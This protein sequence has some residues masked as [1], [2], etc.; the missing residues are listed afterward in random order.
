[1]IKDQNY[2]IILICS[3]D[4]NRKGSYR[5]ISQHQNLLQRCNKFF[6]SLTSLYS[7]SL[8]FYDSYVPFIFFPFIFFPVV[9]FTIRTFHKRLHSTLDRYFLEAIQLSMCKCRRLLTAMLLQIQNFPFHPIH[10][11]LKMQ[12]LNHSD[13]GLK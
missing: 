8:F 3:V 9:F 7:A 5:K 10:L 2:V 1:M 11:N 6:D 12:H 4:E 13:R